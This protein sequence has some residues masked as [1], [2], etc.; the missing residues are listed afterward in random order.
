M[1]KATSNDIDRLERRLD[2]IDERLDHV[3]SMLHRLETKI[4]QLIALHRKAVD[5]GIVFGSAS[6]TP[7]TRGSEMA[8]KKATGSPV[9]CPCLKPKSGGAKAVMPDITLTDPLP[10]TITL[11]P[12]DASGGV[13]TLAPTDVVQGTLISSNANFIVTPEADTLHFIG[14][15]PPNTAQGSTAD[16]SATLKGTIANS[17]AD[18]TASVHLIL[19]LPPNPVA[20]DLAIVFGS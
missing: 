4:D 18:L 1:S 19:N 2:R 7:V 17:P 13:V 3:H 12:L 14:T 11:Q 9:K 20:V 6:P 5:L 16:L 15:I 10:K 8:N